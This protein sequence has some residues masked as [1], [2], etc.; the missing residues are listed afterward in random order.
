VIKI[1]GFLLLV[2]AGCLTIRLC[3][4]AE[5]PHAD[6]KARSEFFQSQHLN[7][8]DNAPAQIPR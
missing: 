2:G 6:D 1:L 8:T 5:A 4:Q 7:D 3:I